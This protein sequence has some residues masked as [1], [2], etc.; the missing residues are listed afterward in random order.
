MSGHDLK[1]AL[2]VLIGLFGLGFLRI[3]LL[4][5]RRVA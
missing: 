5:L 1:L 4:G 2:L 3:F